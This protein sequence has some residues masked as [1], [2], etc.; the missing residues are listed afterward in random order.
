[1]GIPYD[2]FMSWVISCSFIYP[3][4]LSHVEKV[5]KLE[6]YSYN[7]QNPLVIHDTPIFIHERSWDD[8]PSTLVRKLLGKSLVDFGL[9]PVGGSSHLPHVTGCERK[10]TGFSV[11]P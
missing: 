5:D 10:K 7:H 9:L 3:R 11:F 2:L 6:S 1:M 8:P 4:S